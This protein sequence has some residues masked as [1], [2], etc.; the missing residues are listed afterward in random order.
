MESR[1]I[2]CFSS[3][4]WLF[5]WIDVIY[6][7]TEFHAETGSINILLKIKET[8]SHVISQRTV[9]EMSDIF[10][11]STN[12]SQFVTGIGTRE[13]VP[14]TDKWLSAERDPCVDFTFPYKDY[15][16]VTGV[17]Y[18]FIALY[19]LVIFT[20]VIGNAL[21]IWTVVRNRHMRTVT[22]LY[23]LNLAIADLLVS[24]CVMPLK[25]LEYTAPCQWGIFQFNSLC[26]FLYFI[27]PVFVFASVLTLVAI[28]L[29]R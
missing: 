20:S 9:T 14:A 22:N 1:E 25:L 19:I 6:F 29:E 2:I 15:T 12:L 3:T 7:N 18:M 11:V 13:T 28:S 17:Q 23:I 27:L 21:V 8:R 26:S 24:L 4:Y 16:Q 5:K 10:S